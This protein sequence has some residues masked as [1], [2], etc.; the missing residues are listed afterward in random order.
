M[1]RQIV[2]AII[3]IKDKILSISRIDNRQDFG[4]IGG[5]VEENETL[6]EALLREVFE[7]TG[8]II[9][10]NVPLIDI[11]NYHGNVVHCYLVEETDIKNIN[12]LKLGYIEEGDLELKT[13][14]ELCKNTNSYYDYNS[15][16]FNKINLNI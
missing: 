12:D 8:L 5:D 13:I 9:N 1:Q 3:K 6:Q 7:E 10:D 14:D 2:L 4:L 11:R 16:I 15:D